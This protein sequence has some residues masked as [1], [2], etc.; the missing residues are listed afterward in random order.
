M[1]FKSLFF[2]KVLSRRLLNLELK[3][4]QFY[5][6]QRK[7]C[8]VD[9]LKSIILQILRLIHFE[10]CDISVNTDGSAS[11]QSTGKSLILK[12]SLVEGQNFP[13][14]KTDYQNSPQTIK[15]AYVLWLR[16]LP[17]F[18]NMFFSDC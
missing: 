13:F 16:N 10:F 17:V 1:H 9:E 4:R 6:F 5:E 8:M 15:I 3:R 18:A 11:S 12:S 2:C 7:C 14:I